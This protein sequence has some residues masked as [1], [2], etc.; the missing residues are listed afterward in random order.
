MGGFRFAFAPTFA[1]LIAF[2]SFT[3]SALVALKVR[4]TSAAFFL[5]YHS[6]LFCCISCSLTEYGFV[7]VFKIHL[8]A[9]L[10]FFFALGPY[11]DRLVLFL[12]ALVITVIVMVYVVAF[13]L[14]LVFTFAVSFWFRRVVNLRFILPPYRFL[15]GFVLVGK[16]KR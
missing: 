8:V 4:S 2:I 12:A 1:A 9:H 10:L 15:L 3:L 14:P 5:V 16:R 11:G 7:P 13:L 6:S